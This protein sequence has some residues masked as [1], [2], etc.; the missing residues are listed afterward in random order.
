MS[1]LRRHRP[2]RPQL[3]FL[4]CTALALNQ[5]RAAMDLWGNF[6]LRHPGYADFGSYYVYGRVGVHLGWNRLYDL[7]AERQ[8]WLALGGSGAIPW[9]PSGIIYPPLLAWVVA[10][11]TALPLPLA[12]ACWSVGL[13]SLLLLAWRLVAPA[14]PALTRWT[15]LAITLAM[16]PV[17]FGLLLG[18]ILIAE[19]AAIA[20]A[21]W[22]LQRNH[23]VAAGLL[24]TALVFKPQVAFM[25]PLALLVT[26]RWRAVL[27]WLV[28]SLAIT[29]IAVAT[30]GIDGLQAYGERLVQAAVVAPE[31]VVPTQF[32][33]QGLLGHGLP[34]QL[35]RGLLAV[36]TLAVAYRH[37]R[38]GAALPVAAGLC[39][40][41]LVTPYLH[42]Q[43]LA[44][45]LLAGGIALHRPVDLWERRL[46]VVGFFLLLGISYWGFDL[47]G[48]VLG[49]MLVVFEVAWLGA[50]FRLAPSG[51]RARP[52]DPV[53]EVPLDRTA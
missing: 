14:Q 51:R 15:S 7:A 25:V 1:W 40:S 18:Q 34:T 23:E 9:Y 8:E 30:T 35:L 2:T 39:G 20:A 37:R 21:W 27:S 43:D 46:L 3:I 4:A 33:L 13:L 19:L 38:E 41:L 26:G 24:L 10:P 52:A 17:L 11:F 32:T 50:A 12:Y 47:Y 16:F 45:L 29:A 42:D 5:I 48:A 36:L 22:L 53:A 28:A 31:F 6:L 49:P 44:A